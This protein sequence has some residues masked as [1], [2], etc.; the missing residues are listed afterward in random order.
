MSFLISDAI[1][2]CS[3]ELNIIGQKVSQSDFILFFNRANK[4]FFTNYKIPTT[5]KEQDMLVFDNVFEYPIPTD[6]VGF[7]ELER[8]YDMT[9]PKFRHSTEKEVVHTVGGN[10]TAFKFNRD[11][12]FLMIDYGQPSPDTGNN[13]GANY[14]NTCDSP[15]DNGTWTVSGDGS[16]LAADQQYFTQGSGSLRFLV[17]YSSGVTTLVNSTMNPV[18]ISDFIT[19]GF[20]FLDLFNPNNTAVTSVRIRIGSDALNYY[21]STAT[22]RYR[23]DSIGQSFGQIGFDMSQKTTVG[24]PNNQSTT[25]VQVVITQPDQGGLYRLDNIFIANPT[26]FKLPYYSKY[27]VKAND[28]TY[29]EKVTETGDTLL[30]PM[31]FD[32]AFTYK[33]CELAASLK[34]SDPAEANYFRGE[35][36]PK[37][38][39]LRSKYPSGEPRTNVSYYQPQQTRRF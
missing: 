8:P 17:T 9:Q 19:A 4:Y 5:Q 38:A 30:C 18:D 16:N 11:T 12:Q 6:F 35:L 24:S 28:G 31:D 1:Q 22:T 21:E 36:D 33:V 29:K 23:G 10:R 3:Q 37:E 25:Y 13:L 7:T 32:E 2:D 27:N 15:T 20:V 14:L 26:F 34:L 39:G